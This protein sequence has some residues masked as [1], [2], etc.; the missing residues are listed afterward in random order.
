MRGLIQKHSM[1]QIQHI[2]DDCAFNNPEHNHAQ[3]LFPIECNINNK[4]QYNDKKRD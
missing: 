4:R 1:L 3:I 2:D